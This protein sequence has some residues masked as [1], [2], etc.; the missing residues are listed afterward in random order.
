MRDMNRERGRER[1]KPSPPCGVELEL[2]DMVVWWCVSEWARW[3]SAAVA[4]KLPGPHL[5][6]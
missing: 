6:L 4:V 3:V 1:G 5:S 2:S